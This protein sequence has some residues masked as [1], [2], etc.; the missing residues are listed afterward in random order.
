MCPRTN[1]PIS[2]VFRTS[3]NGSYLPLLLLLP[4]APQSG[5]EIANATQPEVAQSLAKCLMLATKPL[6][7][8]E[9]TTAGTEALYTE[10]SVLAIITLGQSY[11][12][13]YSDFL[14]ITQTTLHIVT[15][16]RLDYGNYLSAQTSS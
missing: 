15:S 14:L 4:F 11:S 6:M 9:P 12:P 5:T 13:C 16:M 7:S 10:P 3:E 8:L 2:S 1:L